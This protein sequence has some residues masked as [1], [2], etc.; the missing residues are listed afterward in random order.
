LRNSSARTRFP[1]NLQHGS[2]H[3]YVE[4]I[5]LRLFLDTN[6]LFSADYRDGSCN[7]GTGPAG[8]SPVQCSATRSRCCGRSWPGIRR[9]TAAEPPGDWAGERSSCIPVCNTLMA[10]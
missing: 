8:R 6:I 10:V 4:A 2:A 5:E 9:R 7:G 3:R 1:T